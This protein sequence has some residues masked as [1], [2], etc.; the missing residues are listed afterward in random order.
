MTVREYGRVKYLLMS[1]GAKVEEVAMVTL[2]K[3]LAVMKNIQTKDN[4][5]QKERLWRRWL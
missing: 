2:E 4:T 1:E 3:L 5:W